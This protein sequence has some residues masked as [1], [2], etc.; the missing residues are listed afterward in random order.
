VS[1]ARRHT[2]QAVTWIRS[3][4]PDTLFISAITVGEIM[5]GI[6]MKMRVDAPAAAPL[7]RWLDE[8]RFVYASRILTVDDA[9]ATTWGRLMGQKTRPVVDALIAATARVNNKVL[10]TRN[11]RDFADMGVEIIDPWALAG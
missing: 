6:M 1:E 8:L 2:P 10:V 11:V 4:Q 7:V 9:V 5:K 3:A